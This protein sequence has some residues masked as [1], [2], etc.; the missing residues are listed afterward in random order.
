MFVG[1]FVYDAGSLVPLDGSPD[2]LAAP[3]RADADTHNSLT[4]LIMMMKMLTMMTMRMTTLMT[5]MADSDADNSWVAT[6]NIYCS[7]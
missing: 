2:S 5:M 3:R 6:G 7:R 1:C 4:M